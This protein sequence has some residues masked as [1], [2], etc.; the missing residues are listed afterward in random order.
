MRFFNTAGPVNSEDHYLL[1]PLGRF[2]L[3]EIESLIDQKK[4]FILHAPRQVGKTSYLLALMAHLN[5][6][7]KVRCVYMN[8]EGAQAARE[9]VAG[10]SQAILSE[11]ALRTRI[12]LQDTFLRDHYREIIEQ[13]S[14]FSLLSSA[15]S[16]FSEQSPL[17]V[18]LFIDEIDTLIGD[19]LIAILRQL[20]SGYDRRPSSFPQS[21][22][23]CGVRDIRDY[24]IH[25]SREKAVITGGSAF[26]IKAKS[27]RMG[28]FTEAE[29]KMLYDQHTVETGQI[30]HEDVI[31]TVWQ[32]TRGQPWLV[33]ALAYEVCFDM[34]AGRDRTQPITQQMIMETKE[35]LILRRETHL[36]QLAHQLELERV[37][38]V[39][40]PMLQGL[41]MNEAVSNDDLQ[42]VIDLGLVSRIDKEPQISNAIYREVIPRELTFITQANLYA[43]VEDSWYIQPDGRLDVDGLLAGFQQFFRENSESWVKRY[44]YQEAGPQ[45]LIQAYLQRVINGGGQIAREYGLGRGRTDLLI[46]WPVPNAEPQRV[47]IELK[48]RY[49]KLKKVIPIA[50]EQTWE[51]MD[52]CGTD[53][54]H[55]I[56][57]DRATTRPWDEK[58][59]KRVEHHNGQAITVWGM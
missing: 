41:K 26:N 52:R 5:Q 51:Y 45:L 32:L 59:F 40:S 55:L 58:I 43:V 15:L 14:E 42:Y 7:G 16:L 47:V 37:Q 27:L 12:H 20:R 54:G 22:I 53:Q 36:D 11:L 46:H 48:I 25:S 56:I 28:D 49:G 18:V 31:P 8:V 29:V 35:N 13:N 44:Q 10:A 23:L 17:P 1:P 33:N 2:D 19:T 57:F 39:I 9:N 34:K 24:R 6:Q 30:F 4:Y 21:I 50:L 3:E 38:R